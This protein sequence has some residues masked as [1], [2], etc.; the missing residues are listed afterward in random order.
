MLKK[1]G[2]KLKE[3]LLAGC[4]MGTT[5]ECPPDVSKAIASIK[6]KMSECKIGELHPPFLVKTVTKY[7]HE[8]FMPLKKEYS[9][10][11]EC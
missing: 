1:I 11:L 8:Y 4:M 5:S 6:Q 3:K 9:Q 10:A 2:G 7:R